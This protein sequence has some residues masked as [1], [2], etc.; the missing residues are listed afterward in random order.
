M[1]WTLY[2]I[3]LNLFQGFLYTWFV[4]SML[5]K[6][7]PEHISSICCALLLSAFYSSYL[8]FPLPD[9]D[10]WI[11]L[12]LILYAVFFFRGTLVQRL[13]WSIIPILVV[14]SIAGITYYLFSAFFEKNMNELMISGSHRIMFTL[15]ANILMWAVL[16]LIVKFY[17]R[18][19]LSMNPSYLL[20]I[21]NLLCVFLIDLLFEINTEYHIPIR[22]LLIG[23]AIS[24]SIGIITIVTNHT[25]ARQTVREQQLLFQ[26]H[27]IKE[28]QQQMELLQE[29]YQTTLQLR[30]DIK[31]YVSD[32]KRL[33]EQGKLPNQ[34][35]YLRQLEEQATPSYCT[36]NPALDSILPLKIQKILDLGIE[37]NGA[38]LHYTG[39]MN[40]SEYLLCSL[41]SNML[42]NAVEALEERKDR[43]GTRYIS[44]EFIYNQAGLLIL[45][46]NPLL[47]LLPKM[48]Q[49]S[50][51][52]K[53]K[54]P[55][56]GLG[57]SIMEGIAREAGGQFD[58][59]IAGDQFRA[60][61]L[62]P[63]KDKS[64]SEPSNDT[65]HEND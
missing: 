40:I 23:C 58:I 38:N 62:I 3:A 1:G 19:E 33:I 50:F 16:F 65:E 13:F 17:P 20:L 59:V 60:I 2:E 10:T 32:I 28:Q 6:K 4:T 35:E 22:F 18:K 21:A 8:L 61:A 26:N 56:H 30:H 39:G 31:A 12:I 55:Y 54:E 41:I 51:L 52:S 45:C 25:I 5:K 36:G 37:F 34:P 7:T 15:T 29:N 43:H 57:I 47:G 46:E 42:D 63:P 27:Q 14:N 49:V 53:K 64:V 9:W 44:L 24:L 48:K 11:F